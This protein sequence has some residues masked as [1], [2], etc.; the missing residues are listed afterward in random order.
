MVDDFGFAKEDSADET[1]L[2]S[3][4]DSDSDSEAEAKSFYY[5]LP[6]NPVLVFHSLDVTW[7]TIDVVRFAEAEKDPGPI[8][9]WI[10][11]KPRSLSRED[12]QVA[13]VGCEKILGKFEIAGVEVAFNAP[14]LWSP[15]IAHSI[16]VSFL[17]WKC[18]LTMD[19]IPVARPM[20]VPE[21]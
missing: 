10:G 3:P 6:S 15:R 14:D 20:V 16:D 19:L 13:A 21:V 4:K 5:G 12:A 17:S 8:V 9:L 11:V 7:T 2:A 1:P 18:F